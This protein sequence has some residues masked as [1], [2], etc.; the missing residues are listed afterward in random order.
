MSYAVQQIHDLCLVV[1]AEAGPMLKDENDVSL[2]IAPAFE[3]EAGMIALPV[4]RLDATFSSSEA[5][6]PAPYCRNSST[7]ACAWRC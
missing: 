7:T 6:L 5:A 1:F 4:N 2:F 3:H